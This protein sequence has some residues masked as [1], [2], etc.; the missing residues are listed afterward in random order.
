MGGERREGKKM[1]GGKE[2]DREVKLKQRM[3]KGREGEGGKMERSRNRGR[4]QREGKAK[5]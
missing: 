1:K 2:E 5:E 3:L 4:R